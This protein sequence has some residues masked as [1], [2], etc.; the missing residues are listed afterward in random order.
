[1]T[2]AF[3]LNVTSIKNKEVCTDDLLFVCKPKLTTSLR[4]FGEIGFVKTKSNIQSKLK[5]RGTICRF[6]GYSV[7][8][9]N[10]VY[11]M[12]NLDVE[13][14]IQS[15][16]IIW[17]N[18]VYHDWIERKVSHKKEIDDDLIAN[19]NIQEVN[20]FQDKLRRVKDQDELKK[21]KVEGQCV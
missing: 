8:H 21:K 2:L 11:R 20:N 14:I 17:L 13:S 12:F 19:S 3:L 16:D 6:F 1:M 7:H 4:S 10:N 18:E 15:R 5:N 9:A